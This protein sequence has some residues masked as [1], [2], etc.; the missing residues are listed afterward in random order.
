MV[1]GETA[2]KQ[3]AR[4]PARRAALDAQA[5]MRAERTEREKRLSALGVAVMIALGERDQLVTRYVERAGA[6]GDDDRARGF[7]SAGGGGVVWCGV[8]PTRPDVKRC[9]FAG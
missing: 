8:A 4:Q 5:K 1:V 3:S 6:A 7:E 9:G 2:G